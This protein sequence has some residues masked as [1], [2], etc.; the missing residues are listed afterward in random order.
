MQTNHRLREACGGPRLLDLRGLALAVPFVLVTSVATSATPDLRSWALWMTVNIGAVA[1]T[2]PVVLTMRAARRRT[3]AQLI[4]LPIAVC[5]GAL[6]GAAKGIATT[7]LAATAD[8]IENPWRDALGRSL[9]TAIIGALLIPSLAVLLAS[10]DRWTEERSLLMVE[11]ARRGLEHTARGAPDHRVTLQQ[12][13]TRLRNELT[14]LPPQH[15]PRT[16]RN[17]VVQELKPLSAAILSSSQAPPVSK[18]WTLLRVALQREPLSILF[19]TGLYAT[20]S[21]AL[22]L[23][24]VSLHEAALFGL[25]LA[26]ITAGLLTITQSLRARWPSGSLVFLGLCVA[27]ITLVQEPISQRTF[28]VVESLNNLGITL[29]SALWL[30]QV[31]VSTTVITAA[32]RE[33]AVI[34]QR[35]LRLLGPQGIQEAVGHGV[36][37]IEG[38]DFAFFIHGDLQNRLLALADRIERHDSLAVTEEELMTEVLTVLNAVNDPSPSPRSLADRLNEVV[39]RWQGVA[40]IRV[41]TDNDLALIEQSLSEQILHIVVEAVNNAVRHGAARQ[42]V[43]RV[44][45]Q[46][47]AVNLTIDDDGF[48]PRRGR[49]GTGSLYFDLVTAKNWQLRGRPEGG[50]TLELRLSPHA[51]E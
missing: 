39:T 4:P 27:A 3:S 12:S 18:G 49:L 50:S 35:L 1:A 30:S 46:R 34:R 43:I 14:V 42:I 16:I 20:T 45:Q 21:S 13:T 2:V 19:I 38:R 22:L 8:L 11:L 29:I 25:L 47:D 37:T 9:N 33:R 23:R 36:R 6:I 41:I 26:A 32:R 28:G 44:S 5:I 51:T 7:A 15:W 31:A 24:H 40:D 48:G 10:R 17:Q